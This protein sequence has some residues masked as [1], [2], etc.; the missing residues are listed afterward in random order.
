MTTKIQAEFL[1]AGI[2][3]EQT[4]VSAAGA[5]HILI[6]DASDNSLK[7]SLVSTIT[8]SSAADDITA[9]DDTVTISTT[10][11][12]ITIDN[13]SS[14]ADIIFKGT[15]GGS[16]ITAL[17]LD[18]SA[19][20]TAQF[21]HDIE[22]V[23]NGL[24][25]MG[26]GGDLILTSDGTHGTIFTNNGTLTLD[27]AARI[28]LSADDNGEIR[29]FDGSSMYA[30]FKDDSDRL[31]IQGLISDADMLLVIND[32][33]SEVTALSIDASAAGA[34]TFNSTVTAT[35]FIGDVVN[36]HTTENTVANDDVIAF[37]DTSA[38]AMRKTAVSNLPG[39]GG[40]GGSSAADDITTGDAAVT[41]ATST[42]TITL[43]SPGD[44]ILDA[45]GGDISLKDGGTEL[46]K[47]TLDSAGLIL[48][49]V[50]SDKDFFVNGNDGGS[51]ITALRLDMS[52]AGA[53]TFNSDV[54]VGGKVYGGTGNFTVEC[55]NNLTLEATG[56]Q[57]IFVGQ[58]GLTGLIVSRESSSIDFHN[59]SG[60]SAFKFKGS[61]DGSNITALTI[62]VADAGRATFNEDIVAQGVYVGSRNASYDLY[63]NGSSYFNGA[64]T[65]DDNITV[66]GTVDGRD[67]AADGTKLDGIAAGA[68]SYTSNQATN[69]SSAVSFNGVTVNAG[70][71]LTL[72]AGN[73]TGEKS[74]KIQRHSNH[75]Y[76]QTAD[77]G[78]FIYRN[79][80][81]TEGL[82]IEAS[83]GAL[84]S[85]NNITAYSDI[86]LK[87]DVKTI[88]NALDKVCAMRGV[89][90]TRKS[91]D[92]R[93]VGVIA[94]EVKE[95]MPELVKIEENTDSFNEGISDIH[96]MK[97]QNTVGLLIE[98]IKELEAKVKELENK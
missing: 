51:G 74:G 44:I 60:N 35:Q 4:Q 14:D 32:G 33:G 83:N 40:G 92:E 50:V 17:T 5:D 71:D 55:G 90:Y 11:G 43:D 3:S 16:D 86:R 26:A 48:D 49:P 91:N 46:G 93:E 98:A 88:E 69:T 57:V 62:E 28:D 78:R 37:Y 96:T 25:R 42:G 63:N 77:A 72:T 20:G 89:E 85:S 6:F 59:A 18:M 10:S 67:V 68:T 34:S 8:S 84:V 94:Q 19:G 7:K 95:V 53:A 64:V 76:F 1:A 39:G 47:I 75:L 41:I 31:K 70:Y 23:D 73:W 97:Y 81:G 87:K 13:G 38:S 56:G 24:L 45:D 79:Q 15:D 65:V 27:S 58:S 30:Q 54:N 22:M 21:S 66:T 12:N 80:S 36:A 29:L 2:I 9:G 61:D 52:A 82:Y